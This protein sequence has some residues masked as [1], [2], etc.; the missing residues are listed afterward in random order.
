MGM[1]QF[2]DLALVREAAMEIVREACCGCGESGVA[3]LILGDHTLCPA[4]LAEAKR[5]LQVALSQRLQEAM[6]G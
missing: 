4:C 2:D 6:R 5:R 1:T 3:I